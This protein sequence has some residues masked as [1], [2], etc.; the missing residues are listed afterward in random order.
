MGISYSQWSSKPCYVM[1]GNSTHLDQQSLTE[2]NV[3]VGFYIATFVIGLIGNLLVL[4]VIAAKH[5]KKTVNDLF[6]MN[7][8]VS[9]LTLIFFLPLHIYNMFHPIRV[10]AFLCHF[11]FPLMT[12]SFFVSV[13]TLTSMAIHRC[14]VILNPFKQDLRQKSAVLWIG[15]LW[16][17]SLTN[18]LPLMIVTRPERSTECI[19]NWPS[20]DH[21][22][23]YTAALFVLQYVLPLVIIAVA[24]IR[25][26]LDLNRSSQGRY[27]RRASAN[28]LENQARRRENSKVTKTLAI[29][30]VIFAVCMLPSQVGWIL[31]DF[32]DEQQQKIAKVIFKFSLVLTVFHSCLNPVVYGSITKQFRR[33]YVKYLSYLCYCCRF[34]ILKELKLLRQQGSKDSKGPLN[35]EVQEKKLERKPTA[36][37]GLISK[38]TFVDSVTVLWASK[39]YSSNSFDIL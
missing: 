38:E 26:G 10:N 1:S 12:V 23:A 19:E 37:E 39:S 31:L 3:R 15:V 30:V 14:H 21:R 36:K 9:D 5:T 4:I 11:I 7:L 17:L 24:Y 16:I 13:Y 34:S 20:F 25:I 27:G 33:G 18:V 29:I 28:I 2:R 35:G 6:I 32:G 22:R 8:A